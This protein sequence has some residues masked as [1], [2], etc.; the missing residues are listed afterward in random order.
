M[1]VEKVGERNGFLAAIIAAVE[2]F[3]LPELNGS[4]HS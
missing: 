2:F 1:A 4:F 3:L